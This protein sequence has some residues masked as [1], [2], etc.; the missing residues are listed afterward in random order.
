MSAATPAL[1]GTSERQEGHF[2]V[3]YACSVSPVSAAMTAAGTSAFGSGPNA[4][5]QNSD[6]IYSLSP[7]TFTGPLGANN[8]AYTGAV[9]FLNAANNGIVVNS[10]KSTSAS[11]SVVTA[12]RDEIGSTQFAFY[13]GENAFRAGNY[14]VA[15][16]LSCA[17]AEG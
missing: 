15:S 9:D 4:F 2:N 1:A 13:T 3:P 12:L 7:V 8:A 5:S 14:T 11:S 6:T 10:S 16:T 17:Q